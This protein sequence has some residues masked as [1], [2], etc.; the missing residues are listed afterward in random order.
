MHVAPLQNAS[1]GHTLPQLPQFEGSLSV[2]V[3][4]TPVGVAHILP[5]NRHCCTVPASVLVIVVM[6]VQT[7]LLQPMFAGQTLPHLPQFPGSNS[8]FEQYCFIP[9]GSL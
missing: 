8:G 2:F 1:T 9:A 5:G 4:S 6:L 3:Q 7:P